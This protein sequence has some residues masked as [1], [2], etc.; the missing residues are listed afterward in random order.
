MGCV[1]PGLAKHREGRVKSHQGL[2]GEQLLSPYMWDQEHV[3][4]AAKAAH[5]L[6]PPSP[7]LQQRHG[8]REDAQGRAE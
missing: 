3:D 6:A 4:Q 7:S 2:M 8:S 5:S 1:G